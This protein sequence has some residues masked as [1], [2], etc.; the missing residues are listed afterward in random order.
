MISF[1]TWST[2]F[3]VFT[4]NLINVCFT[5]ISVWILSS[6]K[7]IF[8]NDWLTFAIK[9]RKSSKLTMK[10]TWIFRTLKNIFF[11]FIDSCI[12][13]TFSLNF[14]FLMS[15]AINSSSKVIEMTKKKMIRNKM[16]RNS[17]RRSYLLRQLNQSFIKWVSSMTTKQM[18]SQNSRF[19]KIFLKKT[20][21]NASFELINMW[22]YILVLISFKS[23]TMIISSFKM[24]ELTFAFNLWIILFWFIFKAFKEKIS[25]MMMSIFKANNEYKIIL[26]SYSV[27]AK[28]ITSRS[29]R[30][31]WITSI[32]FDLDEYSWISSNCAINE[33]FAID[34]IDLKISSAFVFEKRWKNLV[35]ERFISSHTLNISTFFWMNVEFSIT[36]H[37]KDRYRKS[38]HENALIQSSSLTNKIDSKIEI[39]SSKTIR[40]TPRNDSIRFDFGSIFVTL[41]SN[42]HRFDF[43]SIRFDSISIFVDLKSKIIRHQELV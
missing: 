22:E 13:F 16:L 19:C 26:F 36:N 12:I 15:F 9:K 24:H 32:W 37:R 8:F 39:S 30:K 1:S 4:W 23:V 17:Q 11:E 29:S 43:L 31:H 40:T 35:H 5:S 27:F 14:N 10:A 33:L 21:N 25:K 6:Y 28:R 2:F 38:S 3:W 41:I 18:R 34:M 42:R 20:L 7:M